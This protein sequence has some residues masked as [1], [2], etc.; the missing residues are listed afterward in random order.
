MVVIDGDWSVEL[1]PD[2]RPG[3]VS[4][5]HKGRPV[6]RRQDAALAAQIGCHLGQSWPPEHYIAGLAKVMTGGDASSGASSRGA[7][8][9]VPD[10]HAMPSA[11]PA[12]MDMARND[13]QKLH[14]PAGSAAAGVEDGRNW[15]VYVRDGDRRG[16]QELCLYPAAAGAGG[17][18]V[19]RLTARQITGLLRQL[20]M[21]VDA[22]SGDMMTGAGGAREQR[23]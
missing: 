18:R 14:G 19:I 7:A 21:A 1:R 6:A 22:M 15:L 23:G 5:C 12:G 11:A 17:G 8:A 16:R 10:Q 9:G 20:A 3:I 4:L 13:A 2:G